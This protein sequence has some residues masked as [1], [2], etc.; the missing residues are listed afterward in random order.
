M[1]SKDYIRERR[2][3]LRAAGMCID[4]G[5]HPKIATA[6]RCLQ[7]NAKQSNRQRL[8]KH[9]GSCRG[10][11]MT[12]SGTFGVIRTRERS[13]CTVAKRHVKRFAYQREK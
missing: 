9:A 8:R 10:A 5:K 4:C 6:Q 1:T 13:E 3:R 2:H 12:T 11:R 7:C